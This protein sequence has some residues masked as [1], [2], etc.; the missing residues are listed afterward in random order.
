MKDL[1]IAKNGKRLFY[2]LSLT[3]LVFALATYTGWKWAWHTAFIPTSF[4]THPFMLAFSIVLI[5]ALRKQVDYKCSLPKFKQT[6][7]PF[8]FGILTTVVN[9]P[10]A[11]VSKLL[12]NGSEIHH[13]LT[14]MTPLQVFVF[15][16][17]YASV[18]EEF[19]FRGFLM[20]ILKPLKNKGFHLFDRTITMPV[21]V[22]AI[23]FGLAHLILFATGA[24]A[25]FVFRIVVFTTLLGLIAGYY[26]EK[27][28]NHAFAIIVHIAGNLMGLVAAIMKN[29]TA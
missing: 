14:A 29:F 11:I 9:V 10:L 23:T 18:A 17:I 6:L 21:W 19:L 22:S 13:V 1:K 24:S 28:D 20:N 15:V 27:H 16:F 12:G 3:L 2:G 26:Q 8:L 7:R 4:V 25:L 5:L